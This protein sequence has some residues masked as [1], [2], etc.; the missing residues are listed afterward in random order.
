MATH[1]AGLVWG[2]MLVKGL[3]QCSVHSKCSG[4][5]YYWIKEVK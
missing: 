5:V 3:A 1:L 4:D 2:E